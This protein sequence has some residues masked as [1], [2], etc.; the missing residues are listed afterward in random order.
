MHSDHHDSEGLANAGR[1]ATGI[2][3]LPAVI[4]TNNAAGAVARK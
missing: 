2:R 4:M 3:K 1:A